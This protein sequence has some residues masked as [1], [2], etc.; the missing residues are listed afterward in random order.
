MKTPG[1][2]NDADKT[3][4]YRDLDGEAGGQDEESACYVHELFMKR[5]HGASSGRIPTSPQTTKDDQKLARARWADLDSDVGEP[6]MLEM[7]PASSESSRPAELCAEGWLEVSDNLWRKS[8]TAA[9]WMP[10]CGIGY[11]SH[12]VV[13]DKLTG[14]VIHDS[15][16]ATQFDSGR[17]SRAFRVPRDVNMVVEINMAED[18]AHSHCR[19]RRQYWV[20][21]EASEYRAAAARLN[22]LALDRPDILFASKECSIGIVLSPW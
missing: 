19:G 20:S 4:G 3:F 9:E 7:L 22:Y 1:D 15:A 17:M 8:F 13:R 12:S 14:A 18:R 10:R 21:H 5:K 6:E 16:G 11:V 2:K